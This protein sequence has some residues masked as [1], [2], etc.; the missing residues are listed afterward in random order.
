MTQRQLVSSAQVEEGANIE[1]VAEDEQLNRLMEKLKQVCQTKVSTLVA[2]R[3]VMT[4]FGTELEK[5]L[6]RV[7][8]VEN[9]SQTYFQ[10]SECLTRVDQVAKSM[11]VLQSMEKEGLVTFA[12]TNLIEVEDLLEVIAGV[13]KIVVEVEGMPMAVEGEVEKEGI[14]TKG[15]E[16]EEEIKKAKAAIQKISNKLQGF[17]DRLK[18]VY[19]KQVRTVIEIVEIMREKVTK[20]VAQMLLACTEKPP[21]TALQVQMQVQEW[22]TRVSR[23]WAMGSVVPEQFYNTSDVMTVARQAQIVIQGTREAIVEMERVFAKIEIC[24]A[25]MVAR[26]ATG[27]VRAAAEAVQEAEK[28]VLCAESEVEKKEKAAE[29]EKAREIEIKET[30]VAAKAITAAD[31]GKLRE[32]EIETKRIIREAKEKYRKV[33]E[34]K[35]AAE[36]KAR[37]AAKVKVI[38]VYVLIRSYQS[39]AENIV[40]IDTTARQIIL[41]IPAGKWFEQYFYHRIAITPDGSQAYVAYEDRVIMIDTITRK[42]SEIIMI[43]NPQHITIT[44]NGKRIYVAHKDGVIVIDNDIQKVY[45]VIKM[46]NPRYIAITPDERWAYV[47]F[48]NGI[49]LVSI[50]IINIMSNDVIEI[51]SPWHIAITPDGNWAYVACEDGIRVIDIANQQVLDVIISSA[52][53]N[54]F[55]YGYDIAI[56]PDGSRVYVTSGGEDISVIDTFTQQVVFRGKCLCGWGMAITPDGSQAYV[57]CRDSVIMFSANNIKELNDVSLQESSPFPS[58]CGCGVAITPDGSQAYMARKGNIVVIDTVNQKISD[59][60]SVDGFPTIIAIASIIPQ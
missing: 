15:K 39:V 13:K 54:P 10:I 58:P 4:Q 31:Q 44:S 18:K 9:I 38:G 14:D 21:E 56:T 37:R 30:K 59:T 22:L 55:L 33:V 1:I 49:I 41:S 17:A 40:V 36:K 16:E 12:G 48:E 35:V 2:I 5:A 32:Q 53:S 6:T 28:A 50:V 43:E 25:E 8:G 11:D 60:I 45:D 26:E 34:A 23:V 46:K 27:E 29:I 3:S 24:Q 7:E 19:F 20:Q 51:K 52:G 42:T 47:A 57:A